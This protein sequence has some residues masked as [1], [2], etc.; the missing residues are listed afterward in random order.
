MNQSN[1][2]RWKCASTCHVQPL[3]VY[4]SWLFYGDLVHIHLM[5]VNE[6]SANTRCAYWAKEILREMYVRRAKTAPKICQKFITYMLSSE[7][8]LKNL[9]HRVMERE[10]SKRSWCHSVFIYL[11]LYTAQEGE[12]VRIVMKKGRKKCQYHSKI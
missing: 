3:F 5:K 11:R 9:C 8:V 2:C 12:N 4:S 7:W 10:S 1:W 6:A